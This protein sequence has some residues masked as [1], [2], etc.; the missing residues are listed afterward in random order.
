MKKFC[1]TMT[2]IVTLFIIFEGLQAQTTQTQPSQVLIGSIETIHSK[3]LNEQRRILVYVPSSASSKIYTKQRYPVVYLLDGESAHF[4]SVVSIVQRLSPYFCPE[5]IVVG[6]PNTDRT[7]DLTPTH[8]DSFQVINFVDNV[9]YKT[10]GG[11]E[12]FI[13]FIEKELMPHID[14][15]YPTAPYRILIGH[16]LG[17]LTVINTLIHQPDLFKAY[18]AIDPAMSYDNQKLLKETK[19]ALLTNNYSGIALFLGI[20]NTMPEGMDIKKVGKDT[21]NRTEH[22]RSILEFRDYLDKNRQNQ[23]KYEYKYYNNDRHNSVPLITEYDAFRFLF[24][25]YQLDVFSFNYAKNIENIYESLSKQF[26]YEVLPPE[27]IVNSMAFA[28]LTYK[29]FDEALLLLKLN[30]LNYPQSY[31]VYNAMGDFFS[32]KGDK[33][34]AIDNYIKALSIKEVPAVR[35][36]LDKLQGK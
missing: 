23:L 12:K 35:Q 9:S 17:G 27:N 2:I 14:S 16:S 30:I 34:N 20:A 15:L 28:A 33:A 18:I 1:L 31:N 3:V 26:G 22:I 5:M 8:M 29:Y 21:T 19:N 32:N 24:S 25:Y 10:S 7:R 6:I 4:T 13:S 36:K 11:G